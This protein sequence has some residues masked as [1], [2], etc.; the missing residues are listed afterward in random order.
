MGEL[1][2][3]RVSFGSI[4]ESDAITS[5]GCTD[6]YVVMKTLDGGWLP[7]CLEESAVFK[8]TQLQSQLWCMQHI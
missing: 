4:N 5:L 8:D 2:D 6:V 3:R 1:T 7:F